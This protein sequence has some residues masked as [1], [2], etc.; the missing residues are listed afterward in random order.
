[1]LKDTE[2]VFKLWSPALSE[3]A[4]VDS[5]LAEKV[6][7]NL[8]SYAFEHQSHDIKHILISK[9]LQLRVRITPLLPML[10]MTIIR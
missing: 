4:D 1:M 5:F 7:Q 9:Y 2:R 8:S 10:L 3:V 6:D